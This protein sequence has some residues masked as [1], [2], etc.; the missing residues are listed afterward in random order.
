[1]RAAPHRPG[2]PRPSGPVLLPA[3]ARAAPPAPRRRARRSRTA[4]GS[5]GRSYSFDGEVGRFVAVR[6][7]IG[8]RAP[9]RPGPGYHEPGGR[10][11]FSETRASIPHEARGAPMAVVHVRFTCSDDYVVRREPVR[12]AHIERLERLR[13]AGALVAGGPAPDARSAELFYRVPDQGALCA[14]VEEDPYRMV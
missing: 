6:R 14:I 8:A 13:S 2:P 7:D 10:S 4:P 9:A 5:P 11:P 1:M 12:Q 3:A